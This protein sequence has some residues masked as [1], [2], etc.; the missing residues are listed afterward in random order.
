VNGSVDGVIMSLSRETQ[1]LEKYDH[2]ENAMK[3]HL[4][5]ALFD[6]TTKSLKWD[7]DDVHYLKK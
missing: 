1:S 5:V 7:L 4:P 2:F 3:Y 6:R